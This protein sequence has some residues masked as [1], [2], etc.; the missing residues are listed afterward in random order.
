MDLSE[1][2]RAANGLEQVLVGG[3]WWLKGLA[4]ISVER[5]SS[6]EQES[7]SAACLIRWL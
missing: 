3:V 5:G 7:K 4:E 6:L 2:K 1:L